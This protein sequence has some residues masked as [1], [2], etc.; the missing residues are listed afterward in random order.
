MSALFLVVSGVA[1]WVFQSRPQEKAHA[2]PVDALYGLALDAGGA[3]AGDPAALSRFQE[4]QKQLEDAAAQ[5]FRGALHQR[6]ALHAP[7]EQR[8]RGAARPQRA[9]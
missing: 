9:Q 2:V 4:R 1:Y 6:C 5:G 7:H 3:V 8:H